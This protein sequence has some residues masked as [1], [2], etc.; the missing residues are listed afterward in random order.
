M[1]ENKKILDDMTTEQVIQQCGEVRLPF[2]QVVTLLSGKLSV[3]EQKQLLTNL[4]TPGTD[5]YNLYQQGVA[6]GDFKLN[7]DLARS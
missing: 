1:S 7:I 4:T 6:E 2:E 3:S 5:E